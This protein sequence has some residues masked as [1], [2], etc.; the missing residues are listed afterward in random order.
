MSKLIQKKT[1]DPPSEDLMQKVLLSAD[2]SKLTDAE[3]M[4]YYKTVCEQLGINPITKPFDYIVLDEKLVL[5]ATKD[6]AAQLRRKYHID[7]SITGREQHDTIYLVTVTAK[8]VFHGT[9]R[10][11]DS[12]GAVPTQVNKDGKVY[13][14]T[15]FGL[16]NAIMRAE[17]KAK[18]RVTLSLCGLG[19]LD[20]SEVEM[21][22]EYESRP[23]DATIER[24]VREATANA[25]GEPLQAVD[26]TKDNWRDVTCHIGKAEGE[27]LGKK[28]GDIKRPLVK[29]LAE[30]W[31]PKLPS[32]PN[33][34][35]RRLRDAVLF[36][37]AEGDMPLNLGDNEANPVVLAT[38]LVSRA[39]DLVM[40]PDMLVEFLRRQGLMEETQ[41]I[42]D[43]PV[44]RL[45]YLLGDG[46]KTLKEAYE[47][48]VKPRVQEEAKRRRKKL[49]KHPFN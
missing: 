1:S 31:V 47:S 27:I 40:T 16:A 23:S 7:I 2:L 10:S 18:R 29:W 36:A 13:P 43:L 42:T 5:Y 17:T 34:K 30:N 6:C 25:T 48:E 11:D 28:M 20:E 46:W 26:I 41:T 14:L 22:Q 21:V 39:K 32:V 33:D 15:A 19:M 35:D 37:V 12:I 3:R 4:S 44:E 9:E 45:Q 8:G 49:A 24:N 38:L